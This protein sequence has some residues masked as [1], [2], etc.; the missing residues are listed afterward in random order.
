M[1]VNGEEIYL[2]VAVRET[3]QELLRSGAVAGPVEARC[4]AGS[5]PVAEQGRLS[6]SAAP[7]ED[8]HLRLP[9]C[10]DGG[11]VGQLAGA[12]FKG[13]GTHVVSILLGM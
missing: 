5:R 3:F 6:N 4:L 13:F 11:E 8:E 1:P 10:G 2:G 7:V 9:R 12:F